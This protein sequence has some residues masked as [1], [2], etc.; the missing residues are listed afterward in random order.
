M[1]SVH[2]ILLLKIK[3]NLELYQFC[4]FLNNYLPTLTTFPFNLSIGL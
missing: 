3:K 1:T 4:N 2:C